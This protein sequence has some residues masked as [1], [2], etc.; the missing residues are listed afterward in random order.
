MYDFL[1]RPTLCCTLLPPL[2][3]ARMQ[4]NIIMM[5]VVPTER[6]I[7]EL[8]VCKSSFLVSILTDDDAHSQLFDHHP[9]V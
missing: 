3:E 1:N 5:D 4:P 9:M 7:F 2:P 6:K 8:L